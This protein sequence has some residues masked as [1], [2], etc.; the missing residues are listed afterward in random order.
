[1]VIATDQDVIQSS[2]RLVALVV[3]GSKGVSLL[4]WLCGLPGIA[5]GDAEPVEGLHSAPEHAGRIGNGIEVTGKDHVC[6]V[7]AA[8]ASSVRAARTACCSRSYSNPPWYEGLGPV[9]INGPRGSGA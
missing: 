3:A 4:A 2:S 8:I 7:S 5:V 1:V 9:K 6:S